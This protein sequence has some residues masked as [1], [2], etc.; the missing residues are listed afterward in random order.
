MH[1]VKKKPKEKRK[2]FVKKLKS[3]KIL[4]VP[5]AYN[6]LC[7]KLI[8]TVC[9]AMNKD[10][11]EVIKFVDDRPGHD[12]RYSMCNKKVKSIS[13]EINENFVDQYDAVQKHMKKFNGYT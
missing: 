7:A 11:T 5:G 1:F 3:N 13:I 6:P 4:R 2:D 10:S 8:E 12:F 9:K